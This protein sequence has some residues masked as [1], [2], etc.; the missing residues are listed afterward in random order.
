MLSMIFPPISI[1]LRSMAV[2]MSQL[3]AYDLEKKESI[4]VEVFLGNFIDRCHNIPGIHRAQ[5][6]NKRDNS[7]RQGF[8]TKQDGTVA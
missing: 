7:R 2:R 1:K 4:C 5:Q 6:H 8:S 3:Y